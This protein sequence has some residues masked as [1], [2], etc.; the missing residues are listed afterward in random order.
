MYLFSL[1]LL[2]L[3]PFFHS[4][5]T[6]SSARSFLLSLFIYLSVL[7]SA[8]F[9]YLLCLSF[10]PHSFFSISFY[11]LFFLRFGY[12]FSFFIQFSPH[13]FKRPVTVP[14]EGGVVS[15]CLSA[16]PTPRLGA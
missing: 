14:S 16:A 7:L 8:F 3:F 11:F 6:L 10:F 4:F 2:I 13:L 12:P 5:Y 15:P 9:L 1:F